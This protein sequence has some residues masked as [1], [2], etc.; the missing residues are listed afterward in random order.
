M[1]V[2]GLEKDAGLQF[3]VVDGK[4]GRVTREQ[5]LDMSG[6]SKIWRNDSPCIRRLG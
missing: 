1:W 2:K 3:Q 6:Y 5:D 4:D